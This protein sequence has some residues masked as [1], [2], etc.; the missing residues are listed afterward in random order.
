MTGH[1]APWPIQQLDV[2]DA[3]KAGHKPVP[4]QQFI[5]KIHSRCNLAC[6][7]CYVYEMADQ[8]WRDMP[9][10]MSPAVMEMTANR[11]DEHVQAHHLPGVGVSLDGDA[12]ATGRH[13]LYPSGRNSYAAVA[14]GLH[15]LGSPEFRVIYGGI[16]CA[17]D[18]SND[19][20][21]TY[22]SLLTFD[23]PA[24]DLLLPH[25]NWSS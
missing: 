1:R 9:R 24:V 20:I 22:E 25:A 5:L 10:L 12:E 19:P 11:I 15:L 23:P 17:I 3:R 8:G 13:R 14:D 16:L 18:V 21:A 6:T 4:F 2:A 7:Y